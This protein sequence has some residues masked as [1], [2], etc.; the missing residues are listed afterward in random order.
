MRQVAGGDGSA[1]GRKRQAGHGGGVSRPRGHL[2]TGG[3]VPQPECFVGVL[4]VTAGG[5]DAPV[6]REGDGPD[7]VAVVS[8]RRR[9]LWLRR[10]GPEV[11]V[12]VSAACDHGAAIRRESQSVDPVVRIGKRA[13]QP[14]GRDIPQLGWLA[15][16]RGGNG[17]PVRRE[18]QSTDS[19]GRWAEP[20]PQPTRCHIPERHA[21]VL[22]GSADECPAIGGKNGEPVRPV[23]VAER[24]EPAP[25][26]HFPEHD[27]VRRDG[28]ACGQDAAVGRQRQRARRAGTEDRARCRPTGGQVQHRRGHVSGSHLG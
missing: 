1:V 22:V 13:Q 9:R 8:D 7:L 14:A 18:R 21:A 25:C 12:M 4:I 2:A 20:G 26:G 6:G 19:G 16:I 27:T 10:G 28:F 5:Q 11:D 24:G 3:D 23:A 17:S 15:E